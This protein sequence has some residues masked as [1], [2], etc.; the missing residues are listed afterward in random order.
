[1]NFT[2]TFLV[3][4]FLFSSIDPV[5]HSELGNL[6]MM[7]PGKRKR[8]RQQPK[9]LS[10]EAQSDYVVYPK[11]TDEI[12]AGHPGLKRI[13][14]YEFEKAMSKAE[15][16][17]TKPVAELK[18]SIEELANTMNQLSRNVLE[19]TTKKEENS[20]DKI[21]QLQEEIA[22]LTKTLETLQLAP[23]Q[24]VVD[25]MV[26]PTEHLS[27]VVVT[28]TPPR[29]EAS[30]RRIDFQGSE[31]IKT[32]HLEKV[33]EI[34]DVNE[35]KLGKHL[36]KLEIIEVYT[37]LPTRKTLQSIKQENKKST[38]R[39]TN[40]SPSTT[41]ISATQ[42]I[43]DYTTTTTRRT[44]QKIKDFTYG[45]IKADTSENDLRNFFGASTES[46]NRDDFELKNTKKE[47]LDY[48]SSYDSSHDF[49]DIISQDQASGDAGV[50]GLFE[51]MGKINKE[52]TQN[53]DVVKLPLQ[54]ENSIKAIQQQMR[55]EE[56]QEKIRNK[57][58]EQIK[59]EEEELRKQ[60]MEKL[61]L[62][63]LFQEDRKTNKRVNDQ[64]KFADTE[65]EDNK[66]V[67]ERYE[68]INFSQTESNEKNKFSPTQSFDRLQ[69]W[70]NDASW[71][72]T[73]KNN[74]IDDKPD[75]KGVAFASIT[76]ENVAPH[77]NRDYDVNNGIVTLRKDDTNVVNNLDNM[78]FEY[79][80]YEADPD[81]IKFPVG[82]TRQ[83]Y[84]SQAR[85]AANTIRLNYLYI[86]SSG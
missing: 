60:Q 3:L 77:Q 66:F 78:E 1:M 64:N 71:Q 15:D 56:M 65:Y 84:E 67:D 16:T 14:A 72:K 2:P 68:K 28:R 19:T 38:S 61:K 49:N 43:K 75:D 80:Y 53:F 83:F 7:R 45:S 27:R 74:L 81:D 9:S 34:S 63:N 30:S 50:L 58:I 13:S 26:S 22:K 10:G 57:Q 31:S 8:F 37:E 12:F 29:A 40:P 24:P 76:I 5:T 70:D 6:M 32:W 17:I 54:T 36:Q 11:N 52:A 79:E 48:K 69:G 46:L 85:V 42:Q 82:G 33:P 62:F 73:T 23:K 47:F 51:M 21:L 41:T 25:Q 35:D 44:T 59:A 18:V 86:F 39:I 55:F 4:K 20:E